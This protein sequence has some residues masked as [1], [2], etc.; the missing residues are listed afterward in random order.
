MI[1][2]FL[3][4]L[5]PSP[6]RE[7]EKVGVRSYFREAESERPV[8]HLTREVPRA[9]RDTGMELGQRAAGVSF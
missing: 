7:G 3:S 9:G 1:V 2:R 4:W 6:Q 8:G 5:M